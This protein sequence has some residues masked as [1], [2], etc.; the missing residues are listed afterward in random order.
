MGLLTDAALQTVNS[1][2]EGGSI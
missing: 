2:H 1:D